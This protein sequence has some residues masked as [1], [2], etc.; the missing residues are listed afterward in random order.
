MPPFCVRQ[1]YR[2]YC[3]SI[4]NSKRVHCCYIL[5]VKPHPTS[6]KLDFMP[7]V[8]FKLRSKQFVWLT[9]SETKL[10]LVWNFVRSYILLSSTTSWKLHFELYNSLRYKI[11]TVR[12]PLLKIEGC[13][14][15][16]SITT[17]HL[18]DERPPFLFIQAVL[19]SFALAPVQN[20]HC[21]QSGKLKN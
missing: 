5:W 8:I 13:T 6:F 15:E 10:L 19:L 3:T 4:P 17:L 7:N 18:R 9:K 12:K 11:D 16:E 2:L 20:F 1:L 21:N 14:S